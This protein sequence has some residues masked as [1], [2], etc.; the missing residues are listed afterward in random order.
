MKKKL[1][2]VG[3]ISCGTED[4][5]LIS[6]PCVIED[7]MIMMKTAEKLKEV[8]ARLNLPIIYK[9][10]FQ[11]DNR[12]SAKYYDGP[13]LDKGVKMLAKIKEQFGFPVLTDIHYPDQAKA[14][15]EVV[16]V[17]QIPAYLCMQT[18]LVVAAAKTGRVVNVKHGQF[19]APENMKHPVHKIE[20]A[21]NDKIILT[22]RGYT[23][24]YNDLVVDPRSFY[25]LNNIGYPVV[26]DITHSIRKY[27][28]PSADTKGGAREFLPV[29]SRAGIAA[30][31][32]GVFIETHPEPA[33]ALCDAASQLC[34]YD[35]EEFMKPI[36]ELH[37]VEVKYRDKQVVLA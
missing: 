23:F 6:G 25:H 27:G 19:L 7:E 28:I 37:A 21:G 3:N 30:G 13:G 10:S 24:G 1:V 35:L 32:D 31:V 2:Q 12:S 15:G 5:F 8:S 36:L 34:V 18:T 9:S 4:L 33:K 17:L 26:F 11:K 22:E 20:E 14:A 29:L 16:D